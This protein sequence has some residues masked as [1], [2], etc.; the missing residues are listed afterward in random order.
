VNNK[1][2]SPVDF[3]LNTP[4]YASYEMPSGMFGIIKKIEMFEGTLDTYCVKCNKDSSVF[5]SKTHDNC[6][7]DHK[8]SNYRDFCIKNGNRSFTVE[9]FCARNKEHSIYF[10]FN[11]IDNEE[12]IKIGQYP[13]LA[14]LQESKL[15]KYRKLNNQDYKELNRA[16]NLYSHDIGI[17]A[18]VYLRRIF[19]RLIESARKKSN[20]TKQK[21]REKQGMAD[22]ISLLKDYLPE[23]LVENKNIYSI[24]SIGLHSLEE[25]E[26]RKYFNAIK[27][28]IEIILDEEIAKRELEKKKNALLKRYQSIESKIKKR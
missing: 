20:I 9:L 18:F 14:D 27:G 13:S 8:H 28:G 12:I 19:E 3:F 16:V 6:E 22:K 21:L 23:F 26:C 7:I 2:P 10:V 24:L 1:I 15:E 17:G 11:I 25:N 4:L 5:Q